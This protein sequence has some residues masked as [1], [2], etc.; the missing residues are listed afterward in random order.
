MVPMLKKTHET[1]HT[2]DEIIDINIE[3]AEDTRKEVSKELFL[4]IFKSYALDFK[5]RSLN[6]A[7]TLTLKNTLVLTGLQMPKPQLDALSATLPFLRDV[8][9]IYL[10]DNS[11]SD[12]ELAQLL[13]SIVGL[14]PTELSVSGNKIG[15]K[16]MAVLLNGKGFAGLR[17]F[18]LSG[19]RGKK[20]THSLML[21]F[22]RLEHMQHLD[23][24]GNILSPSAAKALSDYLGE[25][26][27]LR[28]LNL[29]GCLLL[30]VVVQTVLKA[31]LHDK[32]LQ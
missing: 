12:E 13:K 24:S 32:D 6:L 18:K 28:K 19:M 23:I 25:Q 17:T 30:L 1:S 4:E 14:K 3:A 10:N 22:C 31:L 29:S 7:K 5:A 21:T 20:L 26:S 2:V 27:R 15:D 11:L 9:K 8:S 16:C